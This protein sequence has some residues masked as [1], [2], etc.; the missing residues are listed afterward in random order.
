MHCDPDGHICYMSCA[1]IPLRG[2]IGQQQVNLNL[3]V[4][5]FVHFYKMLINVDVVHSIICG[6]S[7]LS[8]FHLISPMI[9][10]VNH[11]PS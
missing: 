3:K 9:K 4:I 5:K 1:K 10:Y 7:T 11:V 8:A 2:V 6:A